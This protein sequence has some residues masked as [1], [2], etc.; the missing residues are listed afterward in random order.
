MVPALFVPIDALPLT[1]NGK[2]DRLAL[3]A[4]QPT[5]AGPRR[6]AAHPRRA[7]GRPGPR[8]GARRAGR[9]AS[10]TT[11]SPSAAI[12]CW[13]RRRSHGSAA[14]RSA[15]CSTIRPSPASP[16]CSSSRRREQA[17]AAPRPPGGAAQLS[18]AQRAP[19][20]PAP[21]RPGERRLQHVQRLRLRGPLDPDALRAAVGDLAARHEILRTRY[22]D[23]DGRPLLIVEP[24]GVL[25]VEE[26]E[27]DGA[28]DEAR[29]LVAARVNAPFDLAAAPPAARRPDPAGRGRPR[30]LPRPASHPR[31]RLVAQHPARRPGRALRRPTPR[32]RRG[33]GRTRRPV[34]R[35]RT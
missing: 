20:V 3:P 13:P 27:L 2:I 1:P 28:E 24:A 7:P 15:N 21:A 19:L 32:L 35:H 22:P 8:R 14:C 12:R 4:V 5:R 25:A 30:R 11:S 9:S 18:P 33:A 16:P 10:T 23:D 26:I 17:A 29:R 31:R 6:R 34:R